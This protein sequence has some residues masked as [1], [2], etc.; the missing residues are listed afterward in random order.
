MTELE[1]L[2]LILRRARSRLLVE[3]DRKILDAVITE[4]AMENIKQRKEKEI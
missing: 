4:L 3:K 1:R 2:E